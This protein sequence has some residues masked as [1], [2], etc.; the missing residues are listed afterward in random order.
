METVINMR[1]ESNEQDVQEE[2]DR[3]LNVM[4]VVEIVLD[5]LSVFGLELEEF[6]LIVQAFDQVKLGYGGHVEPV[7]GIWV[8]F[9]QHSPHKHIRKLDM[10]H[11]RAELRINQVT[12]G[13][14][15]RQIVASVS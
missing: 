13:P 1:R 5:Y 2:L 9:D 4:I 6:V 11:G 8:V 7:L 3:Y 12:S 15:T 14:F 10:G